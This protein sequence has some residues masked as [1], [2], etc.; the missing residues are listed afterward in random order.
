M[1]GQAVRAGTRAGGARTP[2]AH[3]QVFSGRPSVGLLRG[4]DIR[5]RRNL[6]DMG[7]M[8]ISILASFAAICVIFAFLWTRLTVVNSGYEI[9]KANTRRSEL[10]EQNKRLRVE[11]MKLKSPE[12]IEKAALDDL[13][14]SYPTGEQIATIRHAAR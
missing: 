5:E 2:A 1:N 10:I 7:F 3:S 14:L 13:G 6:K 9:S 12:R 4:Q 8:F 11:F